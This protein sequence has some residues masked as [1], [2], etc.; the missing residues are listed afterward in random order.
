MRM[1]RTVGPFVLL[2]FGFLFS[3][4]LFPI[5]L[6]GQESETARQKNDEI[7]RY[8]E[9]DLQATVK[10]DLD[11]ADRPIIEIQFAEVDSSGLGRPLPDDLGRLK[12]STFE[13]LSSLPDLRSLTFDGSI[14]SNEHL[15]SL[16]SL[17][18]LTHLSLRSTALNTTGL[19]HVCNIFS[20]ESLDLSYIWIERMKTVDPRGPL[21]PESLKLLENLPSLKRLGLNARSTNSQQSE[22]NW[23]IDV[24]RTVDR[25]PYATDGL[26]GYRGGLRDE[27]IR[28]LKGLSLE[29]L[30]LV[31][32]RLGNDGIKKLIEWQPGLRELDL[33]YCQLRDVAARHLGQLKQ[34]RV[35][36]LKMVPITMETAESWSGLKCLET[37]D[38]YGSPVTDVGVAHLS[39]LPNL[40]ELDLSCSAITRPSIKTLLSLPALD[41]LKLEK[42]PIVFEDL[43]RLAHSNDHVDLKKLLI[44]RGRASANARGQLISANL[45]YMGLQDEDLGFLEDHPKLQYLDLGNNKITNQ[46]LAHVASLVELRELVL[47]GNRVDDQG[48]AQLK[49]LN[50]LE[51]LSVDGTEVTLS[52]LGNLFVTI[53]GRI[54]REALAAAGF[55][56]T[57]NKPWDID[58]TRSGASDD[59]MKVVARVDGI[60]GLKLV[61]NQVTN[62]GLKHFL[63]HPELE[64]LWIEEANV[65]GEVTR[66]LSSISGLK[67][68]WCPNVPIANE[69]LESLQ[70]LRHLQ[71]LNLCGCPIDDG[72]VK[73]LKG[74]AS[75]KTVV[76]DLDSLSDDGIADLKAS[77]PG[78][79]VIRSQRNALAV[80]RNRSR[81]K[82]RIIEGSTRRVQFAGVETKIDEHPLIEMFGDEF[83]EVADKIHF[84][85]SK[86]KHIVVLDRKRLSDLASKSLSDL[87]TIHQVSFMGVELPDGTFEVLNRMPNLTKMRFYRTQLGNNQLKDLKQLGQLEELGLQRS[88]V[89]AKQLNQLS[90]MPSLKQLFLGG[91]GTAIDNLDFLE[92]MR[93]LEWLDVSRTKTDDQDLE[94]VSNLVHLRRFSAQEIEMTD[95]G[96]REL[97]ALPALESIDVSYTKV[98]DQGLESLRDLPNLKTVTATD[99]GVKGDTQYPFDVRGR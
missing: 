24:R 32:T 83:F 45:Q 80:M 15:S 22:Q 67:Q 93:N 34:L 36:K 21:P 42:T 84:D 89:T 73:F 71:V 2:S 61:G 69:D 37:L 65:T 87:A 57:Y 62:R 11:R 64:T 49:K 81:V 29:S 70:E 12:K 63:S 20:L 74:I 28:Y 97:S 99:T 95:A 1:T 79:E 13:L 78:V 25:P 9:R 68:L 31:K 8:L 52:A 23:L 44:G 98:T 82:P 54:P 39:G 46:G 56:T 72:A 19:E 43:Q 55:L 94:N 51:G 59:D 96:L 14:F 92:K 18:N 4:L 48:I 77:L 35:L 16:A 47:D 27:D 50:Q 53:Q 85:S 38:L 66:S 10:R 40:R 26:G 17:P 5:P 30:S 41:K 76:V 91:Y 60:H 33:S 3:P 75:L 88:S 58:L 6:V 7:A 90:A 86:M